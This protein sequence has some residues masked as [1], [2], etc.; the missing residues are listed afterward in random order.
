MSQLDEMKQLAQ[1]FN[2]EDIPTL[3]LV[4]MSMQHTNT[5]DDPKT[6]ILLYLTA[7]RLSHYKMQ[8][9]KSKKSS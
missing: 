8:H 2:L 9:D 6:K 3:D 4:R 5:I 1:E 7:A